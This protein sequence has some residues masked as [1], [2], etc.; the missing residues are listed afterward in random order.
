MKLLIVI[1][2]AAILGGCAAGVHLPVNSLAEQTL[3]GANCKAEAA[4]SNNAQ[5]IAAK[6]KSKPKV[7]AFPFEIG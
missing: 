4:T 1:A 2:G 3:D 5:C 6:G 7:D